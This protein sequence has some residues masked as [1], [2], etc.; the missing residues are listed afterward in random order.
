MNR[1]YTQYNSLLR[2]KAKAA[3]LSPQEYFERID[4]DASSHAV[5]QYYSVK[6]EEEQ[7]KANIALKVQMFSELKLLQ[8][9][10]VN[11]FVTGGRSFC[12]WL[13]SCVKDVFSTE[14]LIAMQDSIGKDKVIAL[15]FATSEKIYSILVSILNISD[16]SKLFF[17]AASREARWA[18]IKEIPLN[19]PDSLSLK[20]LE[21]IGRPHDLVD[22]NYYIKLVAGIALYREA[23]PEMICAGLPGD[24]KH[25][26]H[27]QHPA[28]ATLGISPK[29]SLGGTHDSP[30]SH[31]REG[32][33]R[34]L[35]SERFTHKRF[36]VIFIEGTFVK[37]KAQ[38]LLATD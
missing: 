33:F 28:A 35:K 26:A 23:F 25:P 36:Q 9:E 2:L 32:H 4:W 19:E 37:G 22:E 11:L 1:A 30:I 34:C 10:A 29:I 20:M 12:D 16:T 3:R 24:L 18:Y 17:T 7:S 8:G 5:G 6:D 27:H 38:T 31:Y 21:G 15:H 14:C 13:V